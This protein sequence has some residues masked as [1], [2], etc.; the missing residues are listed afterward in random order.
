MNYPYQVDCKQ[1]MTGKRIASTKRRVTFTFGFANKDAIAA[2][3]TGV[4]CRGEE[5][6]IVLLW[7]LTSGKRV[8]LCNGK[9]VHQSQGK[10]ME[11]KFEAQW[12]MTGEHIVKIIAYSMP[13][14]VPAPGFRQYDLHIDGMSFFE[15]D[16]I[17]QLGGGN[18]DNSVNRVVSA[19]SSHASQRTIDRRVYGITATSHQGRSS[20]SL[21]DHSTSTIDSIP[22]TIQ[23]DFLDNYPAVRNTGSA[24]TVHDAFAPVTPE[25]PSFQQISNQAI[26]NAYNNNRAVAPANNVNSIMSMTPTVNHGMAQ[27]YSSNAVASCGPTPY[28]GVP[29]APSRTPSMHHSTQYRAFLQTND[30]QARLSLP[31]QTTLPPTSSFPTSTFR[32]VAQWNGPVSTNTA[33]KSHHTQVAVT[34]GSVSLCPVDQSSFSPYNAGN[35]HQF[36][37]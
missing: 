3:E 7:S 17:Y 4:Q 36:R 10:S 18:K 23:Q 9:P 32:P 26:M 25:T 30:Q 1:E 8:V 16:K 15:M 28:G 34:P 14:L 37:Y 33:T 24:S 29:K 13:S 12:P 20:N 31:Q 22:P 35:S 19:S 21:G 27:F 2:G 11:T 6:T 5:F